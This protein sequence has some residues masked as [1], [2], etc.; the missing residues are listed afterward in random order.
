M[1]FKNYSMSKPILHRYAD[2]TEIRD[3]TADEL[4]E[5]VSAAESDGGA[6]VILVDGIACY[7]ME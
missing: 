3:A 1:K 2:A 7:V 4:R 5:S 6:G